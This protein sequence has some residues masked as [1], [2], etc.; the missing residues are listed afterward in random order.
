MN[1]IGECVLNVLKGI[2]KLLGCSTRKLRKHKAALCKVADRHVSLW[3]R[4]RF[5]V[6]RG[7]F[8]LPLLEAILPTIARI[9]SARA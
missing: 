8:I 3:G 6:Q 1:C 5:I 7:G 4:K 2:I 9:I